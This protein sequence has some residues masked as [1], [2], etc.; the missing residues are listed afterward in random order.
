V[1][2]PTAFA[3]VPADAFPIVLIFVGVESGRE[4]HRIVVEGP[5]SVHIPALRRDAGEPIGVRIE[6]ANGLVD[7]GYQR[8]M[9][10]A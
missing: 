1:S 7:T 8:G 10:G 2:K 3:D 5:G 6:Y 9:P 4:V